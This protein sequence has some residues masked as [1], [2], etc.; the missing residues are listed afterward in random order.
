MVSLENEK[1]VDKHSLQ[2]ANT[3]QGERALLIYLDAHIS[4]DKKICLLLQISC[5]KLSCLS[6]KAIGLISYLMRRLHVVVAKS[7]SALELAL[8]TDS[9]CFRKASAMHLLFL[10]YSLPKWP[11]KASLAHYDR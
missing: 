2:E 1:H 3:Y 5:A 8:T 11:K 9:Q 10:L 7:L 4:D 6:I